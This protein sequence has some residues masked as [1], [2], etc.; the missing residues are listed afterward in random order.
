L[1]LRPYQTFP[2]SFGIGVQGHVGRR[3]GIC[4]SLQAR[5]MF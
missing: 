3:K 2:L 4:G 5:F 1:T